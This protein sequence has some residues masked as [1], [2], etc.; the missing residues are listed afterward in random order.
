MFDWTQLSK[1]MHVYDSAGEKIGSLRDFDTAGGYMD[2]QKG[3][4]FHKDFYVPVSAVEQTTSEGVFLSLSKHDLAD[5]IYDLPPAGGPNKGADMA[6]DVAEQG[7]DDTTAAQ[8][9]QSTAG[10]GNDPYA[11]TDVMA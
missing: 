4:L 6:G 3:F 9:A 2:V 1:G 7:T 8:T 10:Q 11:D 5:P